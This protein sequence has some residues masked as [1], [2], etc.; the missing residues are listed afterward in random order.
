MFDERKQYFVNGLTRLNTCTGDKMFIDRQF[1]GG[2]RGEACK[3]VADWFG[4]PVRLFLDNCS[5]YG[6]GFFCYSQYE[7][8]DG[9]RVIKWEEASFRVRLVQYS[10]TLLRVVPVTL[11]TR[12]KENVDGQD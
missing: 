6:E 2:T 4:I 1:Y 9:C 8:D 7:N 5:E 12:I 10:G 3:A 11:P